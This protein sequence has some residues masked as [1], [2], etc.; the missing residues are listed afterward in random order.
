[1]RAPTRR[2]T[3]GSGRLAVHRCR[4]RQMTGSSSSTLFVDARVARQRLVTSAAAAFLR[5]C[6]DI[7]DIV[8]KVFVVHGLRDAR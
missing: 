4:Q 1:M 8:R 7:V 2:V 3:D 5:F 6:I